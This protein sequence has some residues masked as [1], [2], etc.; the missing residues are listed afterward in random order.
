MPILEENKCAGITWASN[1]LIAVSDVPS[2]PVARKQWSCEHRYTES[3]LT[4]CSGGRA[5][6]LAALPKYLGVTNRQEGAI[7]CPS[8]RTRT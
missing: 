1:S 5:A 6:G 7:V 4:V 8:P 3:P 2:V